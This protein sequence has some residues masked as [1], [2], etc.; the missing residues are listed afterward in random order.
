MEIKKL[1]CIEC[2]IGCELEVFLENGEVTNIRGNSCPRGR[3]YAENEVTC[4]RRVVTSSIRAENGEMVSVKTDKPIRK[5]EMFAVMDIIAKTT[6]KLPVKIG[7]VLVENISDDA[8][9]VATSN[10]E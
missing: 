10:L 5:T 4:P 7:D 8:N 2:P 9:L 6:C 1:V 3:Y